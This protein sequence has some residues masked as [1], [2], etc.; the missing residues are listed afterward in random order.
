MLNPKQ[1]LIGRHRMAFAI[2]FATLLEVELKDSLWYK[3]AAADACL[4]SSF[5]ANSTCWHVSFVCFVC[6]LLSWMSG[7]QIDGVSTPCNRTSGNLQCTICSRNV[8]LA[9][10]I[11]LSWQWSFEKL[12]LPWPQSKQQRAP[13]KGPLAGEMQFLVFKMIFFVYLRL[14]HKMKIMK[15]SFSTT[16]QIKE[17]HMKH[18]KGITCSMKQDEKLYLDMNFIRISNFRYSFEC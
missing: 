17:V 11:Y 5:Y 4:Q 16:S 18:P 8:V 14:F 15:S 10:L 3:A 6:L 2:R 7:T 13:Q 9:L 12:N 1:E